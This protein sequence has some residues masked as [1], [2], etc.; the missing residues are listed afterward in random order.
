[1]LKGLVAGLTRILD[2][3]LM[4]SLQCKAPLTCSFL[5]L[6]HAPR[7]AYY[8]ARHRDLDLGSRYYDPLIRSCSSS[9]GVDDVEAQGQ[10][11]VIS[12]ESSPNGSLHKTII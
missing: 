4:N 8:V 11:F 9:R 3:A 7:D 10:L 5:L 1:M 12:Y 6:N 2:V